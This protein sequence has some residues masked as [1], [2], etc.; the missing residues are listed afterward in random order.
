V[1]PRWQQSAIKSLRSTA[2]IPARPRDLIKFTK[3]QEKLR[4]RAREHGRQG[5]EHHEQTK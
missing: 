2:S 4:S 1:A 3:I 5:G